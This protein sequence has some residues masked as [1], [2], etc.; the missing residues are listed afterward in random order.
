MV[1]YLGGVHHHVYTLLVGTV[2]ILLRGTNLNIT[3][4]I[5]VHNAT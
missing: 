4:N 5:H 3:S 1:A 2:I